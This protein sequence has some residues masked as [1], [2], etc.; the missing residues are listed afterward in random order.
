MVRCLLRKNERYDCS[1][2]EGQIASREDREGHIVV[3]DQ[4]HWECECQKVARSHQLAQKS[5]TCV[6]T[7][8]MGPGF[9]LN[10]FSMNSKVEPRS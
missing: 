3:I 4:C 2:E 10:T 7:K 8:C 9:K 1:L 5:P 6:A